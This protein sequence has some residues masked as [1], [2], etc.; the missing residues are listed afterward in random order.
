MISVSTV[1]SISNKLLAF[2]LVV[3]VTFPTVN[4]A[5]VIVVL[6]VAFD[7]PF[8][9]VGFGTFLVPTSTTF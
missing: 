6:A 4:P 9:I 2:N 3:L 8:G 5:L 7:E 1:F